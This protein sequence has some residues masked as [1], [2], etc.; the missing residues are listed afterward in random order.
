VTPLR[1]WMAGGA[2]GVNTVEEPKFVPRLKVTVL[3]L[4]G[5]YHCP[6]WKGGGGRA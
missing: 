6:Y 4:I 2:S 5:S 1:V 3:Q